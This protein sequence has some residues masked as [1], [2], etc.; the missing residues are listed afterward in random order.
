[1]RSTTTTMGPFALAICLC[2]SPLVAASGGSVKCE[3]TENGQAAFGEITL[4]DGEKQVATGE[5]GQAALNAPAGTYVAILSLDGALDG[6]EQRVEVTLK[7]GG[8]ETA[9]ADFATGTLTVQIQREGRRAAGMAIVRR[10]GK[11]VGTLG[12]GVAARLSAG[13]YEVVVRYRS[14][15]REFKD[16]VVKAGDARTL[17]ATF[18]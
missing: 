8:T 2:A 11:Q 3:I 9:R 14:Q 12:S 10:D 4:M 15:T 1:M 17:E 5:C 7:A 18:E 6:P 16:V 13:T